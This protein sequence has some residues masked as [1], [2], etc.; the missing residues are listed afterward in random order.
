M[1]TLLPVIKMGVEINA[2]KTTGHMNS[3]LTLTT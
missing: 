3:T 1:T 2:T